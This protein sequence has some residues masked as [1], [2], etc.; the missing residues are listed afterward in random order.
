MYST[1]TR[2]F[3]G[4]VM[5]A[6]CGYG[7]FTIAN[8]YLG[9]FLFS[10]GL[11]TILIKEL[12]LFTGK[13]YRLNLSN[14]ANVKDKLSTLFCNWVGASAVGITFRLNTRLR[15]DVLWASKI[16]NSWPTVFILSFFCGV[17]MYLAVTLY[18]KEHNPLYVIMP[19]MMFILTGCEHCIANMF[20]ICLLDQIGLEHLLY[21]FINIIGNALGSIVFFKLETFQVKG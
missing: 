12:S 9:A 19:I 16:S 4:G 14:S 15:T 10:L 6:F 13:I 11:L 2:S 5:I 7:Y 17:L 3:L 18:N 21:I 20:Y 1:N 8:K